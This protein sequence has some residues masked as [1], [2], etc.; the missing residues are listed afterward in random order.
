MKNGKI[1]KLVFTAMAVLIMA[2]V[3][4]AEELVDFD[5]I[6]GNKSIIKLL[7]SDYIL[8]KSEINNMKENYSNLPLPGKPK[9]ANEDK[10]V[11]V[12]EGDSYISVDYSIR[13]TIDRCE[14]EGK[15]AFITENLKKLIVYGRFDEKMSFLESD[16]YMFPE[17]FSGLSLEKELLSLSNRGQMQVCEQ[18][19]CRDVE[20]CGWKEVCELVRVL[21]CGTAG[22]AIGGGIGGA[23]GGG[24]GGAV[25]AGCVWVTQNVCKNVK[26][27]HMVQSCD[28]VC[29][30][31]EVEP[32]ECVT[33][34]HGQTVCQ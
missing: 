31:E 25:T 13:N 22:G 16:S 4:K 11:K 30:W 18:K 9:I 29:H 17:R 27:C 28:T 15:S 19:N 21:V 26:D 33:N 10:T 7:D 20:V 2:G 32:G 6:S 5:G 14:R 12:E 3:A 1:I 8:I 23:T 24:T 34:S